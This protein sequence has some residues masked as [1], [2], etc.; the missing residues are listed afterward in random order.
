M[1]REMLE[2][3]A[4]CWAGIAIVVLPI[5]FVKTAP[6]GRHTPTA[7]RFTLPSRIGW[8]VMESPSAI[9]FGVCMITAQRPLAIA[10]LVLA[11]L[12][13]LH[14]LNRAFVY[15]FRM[16]GGN[17]PMPIYICLSAFSFTSFNGY[18]NGRWVADFGVNAGWA[19][20]PRFAIGVALFAIGFAVNQHADALLFR[21]RG[22]S[23]TG[24]KIPTGGLYRYVSCPNYLGEIVEWCGWALAAWSV[25]GLAFA[26]WTIA[27][28]APRAWSHHR[29]Y[30]ATFPDY[31]AERRALVPGI[32]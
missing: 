14:Y 11:A 9:V 7:P 23:D 18:L 5:L 8:I 20:D 26:V 6:Y 17:R 10:P 13:E 31:P 1:S 3:A 30:R 12:W 25:A 28:L 24:Y 32:Y 29:W 16:R 19:S 21:L 27:N 4:W 22:R 2:I 15:P